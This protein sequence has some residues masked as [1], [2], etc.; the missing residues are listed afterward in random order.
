MPGGASGRLRI[1]PFLTYMKSLSPMR[2][3]LGEGP[4]WDADRRTLFWTDI[5]GGELH[6]WHQATGEIRRVYRGEPVGGF[7]LEADGALALFRVSDIARLDPEDG[8]L[9][10][11]PF[12]DS[13][14]ARFNDVTADVRGRVFAGTIG[15]DDQSGGLFRFDPDGS[16]RLLFRGTGCS[17]G[18]GFSPDGRRMYWTCSTTRKI[19]HF[20]YA[21]DTGEL[22]QRRVFH[23]C[24]PDEGI[25][26]GLCVDREGFV[27]SA[28]WTGS[29][30]VRQS[31]ADGAIVQ[32]IPVPAELVTSCCFG[33]EARSTLFI[34]T[35]RQADKPDE[36]GAGGVY[37]IE[38]EAEGIP[39]HRSRLFCS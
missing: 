1:D 2:C 15:R 28:R 27:W 12:S 23:A 32:T 20:D 13:G 10:T 24:H 19:F 21:A 35:A 11:R 36:S 9:Q 18:M 37:A 26:D 30:I 6:A 7:T 22:T 33:G 38:T 8:R 16:D 5:P 31:P 3:Q 4:L 29:C 39:G 25:P 34:T 14:M 17:N